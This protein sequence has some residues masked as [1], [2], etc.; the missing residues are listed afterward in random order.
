[1]YLPNG[2]ENADGTEGVTAA[3]DPN[4]F[5]RPVSWGAILIERAYIEYDIDPYLTIR[6]GRYLTPYGIWN[7]DHGSPV[8]IAATRPYIIGEQFFPEAQTGLDLYGNVHVGDY[9]VGYHATVSNG[10]SPADAIEDPDKSLAL[11]GRVELEA[12]WAGTFKVGASVY[13]GRFTD[14]ITTPGATPDAYEERSYGGD[15]QWDHGGLHLQAEVI[16]NSRRYLDGQR[17]LTANGFAPDGTQYGYYGL[18]GYRTSALWNVM[19]YFYY[20]YENPLNKSNYDHVNVYVGGLN[21]RPSS[22]VI[23]KLEY[24]FSTLKGAGLIGGADFNTFTSQAAWVF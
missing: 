16:G 17:P 10:R 13:G 11:G 5:T 6:A 7:T 22:S 23:L 14:A 3:G 1:M 15:V 4:D 8:I 12:P 19:P 21:F 2:A 24:S 20:E 18:V 9:R